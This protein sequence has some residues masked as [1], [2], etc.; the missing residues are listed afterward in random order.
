MIKS[1]I[2]TR[3]QLIEKMKIVYQD[4]Y[5]PNTAN[6]LDKIKNRF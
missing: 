5:A 3:N 1:I 2:Q 4:K 6:S